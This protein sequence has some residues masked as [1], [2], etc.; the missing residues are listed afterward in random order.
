MTNVLKRQVRTRKLIAT[1]ILS[2]MSYVL[3]TVFVFPNMAPFQHFIDVLAAV[4]L[5]P[6]YA[7]AAAIMT[8]LARMGF[9]GRPATSVVSI[10]VAPALAA[11]LY[12]LSGKIYM[13]VIG[14]V[15]GVGLFG[16]LFSYP[17]MKLIYGLDLHHFYFYIPFFIPSA[18]VG[19]VLGGWVLYLLNHGQLAKM[20]QSFGTQLDE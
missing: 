2:A 5:G 8:G 19:A 4:L 18:L 10:L 1:A 13:A 6:G 11:I 9:E 16:A 14:E 20:Q 12:R 15:V 17:V 7:T 3:S